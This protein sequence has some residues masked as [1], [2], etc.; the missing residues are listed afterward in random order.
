MANFCTDGQREPLAIHLRTMRQRESNSA[1]QRASQ[2]WCSRPL[3]LHRC[4]SQS[5]MSPC[6]KT[7]SIAGFQVPHVPLCFRSNILWY[8]FRFII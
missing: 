5:K 8:S 2:K 6:I 4:P 7:L 3:Y 1:S